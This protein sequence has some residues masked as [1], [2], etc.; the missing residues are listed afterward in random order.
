M[1]HKL[2]MLSGIICYF[3]SC[4]CSGMSTVLQPW[5]KGAANEQL[6]KLA[7]QQQQT[8]RE[9]GGGGVRG[10]ESVG[11][12]EATKHGEEGLSNDSTEEQVAE[13]GHC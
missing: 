7:A 9:L 13:G 3:L 5:L 4:Q 12:L 1:Q 10:G 2:I 6:E 8:N 11:D